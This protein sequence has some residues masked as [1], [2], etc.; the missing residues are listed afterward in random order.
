MALFFAMHS[1]PHVVRASLDERKVESLEQHARLVVGSGGR[2][3]DD[4]HAAHLVHGVVVAPGRLPAAVREG[5]PDI[6]VREQREVSVAVVGVERRIPAGDVGVEIDT[7]MLKKNYGGSGNALIIENGEVSVVN[8]DGRSDLLPIDHPLRVGHQSIAISDDELA[9]ILASGE[10]VA[11]NADEVTRQLVQVTNGEMT[12]FANFNELA[13]GENFVPE[14][15]A[16]RLD[17]TLG[18]GMVPVTVRREVDGR[19]GTLQFV[20]AQIMTE[21]ERVAASEGRR[22]A[23]PRDI[24]LAAMNVFDTLIGN[25]AR[26]PSSMLYNPD[27]WNLMLV[28]HENSFGTGIDLPAFSQHIDLV[29]G[30]QWRMALTELDDQLLRELLGDAIDENHLAALAKRRDALVGISTRTGK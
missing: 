12:V 3:D 24:Q 1:P 2:H 21:H 26:T 20:P 22:P 16:F 19:L 10:L 27:D 4:V 6:P 17:R 14:L 7:G 25:F 9:D 23:C 28:D 5:L 18:L 29:I 30:D 8:Q 11:T 15:A 13:H